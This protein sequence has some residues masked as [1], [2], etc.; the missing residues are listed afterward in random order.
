MP[1]AVGCSSEL[2]VPPGGPRLWHGARILVGAVLELT[3]AAGDS[4]ETLLVLVAFGWTENHKNRNNA[5]FY[6]LTFEQ[7]L[8][9]SENEPCA[10]TFLLSL[11]YS[12]IC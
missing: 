8:L 1:P 3:P 5:N 7:P 12:I 2:E 4:S 11:V 6:I 10:L 9:R